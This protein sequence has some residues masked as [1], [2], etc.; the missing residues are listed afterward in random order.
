MVLTKKE[1]LQKINN[2]ELVFTPGLDG[3]QLQPHAI[4]FRLGYDFYI[5]K[6]WKLT[7]KGRQAL[8]IDPLD[9]L[10]SS[11]NF[12]KIILKPRQ[13][14]EILPKEFIIGTTLEKIEINS[15]DI[16]GV[17][18]PRS[19]INRRGLSVDLSGVIDVGY[20]GSLIIPILN[21][22]Q[23]QKIRLYPGERICQVV[24][25]KL[26]SVIS[27]DEASWHGLTKAK[28]NGKANFISARSD[29][30]EETELIRKGKIRELKK[31]YQVK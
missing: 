5:P 6:T 30:K 14:F 10:S 31:K 26:T 4:D 24:F 27:D 13:Y 9:T 21:N 17:L 12:E 28:Y 8:T 23:E 1:I 3:F 29:K 22:T 15:N 11:N 16:M 7:K 18:Y 25:Q 20:K 2:S 19:S